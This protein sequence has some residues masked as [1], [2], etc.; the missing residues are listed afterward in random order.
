MALTDL[1]RSRGH[2]SSFTE[3][4]RDGVAGVVSTLIHWN[5]ARKT[6]KI[7]SALSSREL[8]DIGLTRADIDIIA[9]TPHY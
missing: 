2:S 6:R 8:D 3:T 5:D 4:L 1:G 7:L 9:R